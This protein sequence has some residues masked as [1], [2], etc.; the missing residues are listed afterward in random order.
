MIAGCPEAF[1]STVVDY[2]FG[3]SHWSFV[4]V[5]KHNHHLFSVVLMMVPARK[6]FACLLLDS[7][8]FLDRH[9]RGS[10]RCGWQGLGGWQWLGRVPLIWGPNILQSWEVKEILGKVRTSIESTYFWYA[11]LVTWW[12]LKFLFM[13][14]QHEIVFGTP[15]PL[16]L[17]TTD[18]YSDE[19]KA[20]SAY[21]TTFATFVPPFTC[22]HR[23]F[24]GR[25]SIGIRSCVSSSSTFF[26]FL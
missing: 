14:S 1:L 15:P 26:P 12:N 6:A 13:I 18:L 11:S 19:L 23:N 20:F 21:S 5:C 22:I 10:E 24:S 7:R 8:E 2:C 16:P 17:H 9:R 3:C 25:I 4:Y